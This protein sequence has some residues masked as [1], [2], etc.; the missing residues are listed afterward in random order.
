DELVE[1]SQ[2]SAPFRAAITEPELESSEEKATLTIRGFT[3]RPEVQ[4]TNT[5]GIYLFVNNRLV[6]DKL[7]LHAIHEA[8]RNIH[9]HAIS[10]ATLLFLD[11]PFDEVDVN[12]HPKKSEV[13]FRRSQFVHDFTRDVIRQALMSV[14]PIASFATAAGAAPQSQFGASQ[15]PPNGV[16]NGTTFSGGITPAPVES[17][18]PHAVIP[19]MQEA[20]AGSNYTGAGSDGGG[21]DLA[22]AP[23]QPIP[24][25]FAF[26]SSG[27]FGVLPALAAATIP[28]APPSAN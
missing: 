5:S 4:R 19:S 8:Y 13:R 9:P 14:R 26:E 6:R 10:P 11:M 16:A 15:V 2:T 27:G 28:S 1:I 3:S 17:G 22:N 23:L 12:V 24:Q 7:I 21:F 18:I 25:R 20:G